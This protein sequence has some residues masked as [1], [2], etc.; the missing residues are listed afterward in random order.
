DEVE[1]RFKDAMDDDFNTPRALAVLFDLAREARRVMS[2]AARPTV[3]AKSL[4]GEVLNK[5]NFFG[6]LLGIVSTR[7]EAV[8]QEIIDLAQLR[9][10]MKADKNF[11]GADEIRAKVL[12]M[13]FTIEDVKGGQFRILP[14]K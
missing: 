12:G 10:Q 9:V 14:K 3:G 6:G 4:L 11:T 5:L 13:G 8:P 1:N 7:R 2:Q